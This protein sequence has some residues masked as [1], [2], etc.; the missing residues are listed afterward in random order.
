[1]V[2]GASPSPPG[3]RK[4]DLPGETPPPYTPVPALG[5]GD[6]APS[7]LPSKIEALKTAFGSYVIVR[8]IAVGGMG[9]V[10]EGWLIPS[11]ELAAQLLAGRKKELRVVVGV[12]SREDWLSREERERIRAWVGR[13]TEEFLRNPPSSD[14]YREMIEWISPH[15]RVGTDYRRAIKILNPELSKNPELVKRFV[16]EVEFL[17]R[18]NHPNIVKV[19]E[20][21]Q[22]GPFH[23]A[24]ME[25]VEAVPL[26]NLRLSIPEFVHVIRRALEGLI[27]AHEQNVL[28]RDLK[29][30]NLLVSED[31]AKIKL[32]DF[33]IAKA[34]DEAVDGHLTATGVIIGT[35]FYLDPERARGEP[36]TERSDVYSLG[37]TLYR[38]LTGEPPAKA[39]RPME[40]IALIQQDKD[41]PWVRTAN[42][43]VSSELEDAVMMMLSKNASKR[44][45][46]YEARILL[47]DLDGKNAL[48]DLE[49]TK[50]QR[51]AD[52][53]EIHKIK[54]EV[55]QVHKSARIAAGASRSALALKLYA[56]YEDLAELHPRDTVAGVNARIDA[57]EQALEFHRKRMK[58]PQEKLPQAVVDKIGMLEKRCALEYRRLV[59]HGFPRKVRPIR[60]MGRMALFAAASVIIVIMAV[61][62]SYNLA[63]NLR[64]RGRI[65][66]ALQEAENAL[67]S[68]DFAA[69]R[70]S[71]G[72]A[73]AEAVDLPQSAPRMKKLSALVDRAQTSEAY[74]RAVSRNEAVKR[75]ISERKYSQ[76]A[77]EIENI[78]KLLEETV[79]GADEALDPKIDTI[80]KGIAAEAKQIQAYDADIKVYGSLMEAFA[81]VRGEYQRLNVA[82]GKNEFFARKVAEDLQSKADGI[83]RKLSNPEVVNPD[84]VGPE[85]EKTLGQ[86][87]E[88]H[89]GITALPSQLDA[90][91]STAVR[92]E[93]DRFDSLLPTDTPSPKDLPGKLVGAYGALK[94]AQA[95]TGL[96]ARTSPQ[97][98][99]LRNRLGACRGRHQKL[100]NG[101]C[102][103]A[104]KE[105]PQALSQLVQAYQKAGYPVRAKEL[106]AKYPQAKSLPPKKK[107][108]G[109]KNPKK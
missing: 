9:E 52:A 28:H 106:L 100:E 65:D 83:L 69:T 109:D 22:S 50:A 1:M 60:R 101:F 10:W 3:D 26:E 75:F 81:E 71:L 45:T 55:R 39:S 6:I 57:Y 47:K 85:F 16:Q 102:E 82:L 43:R 32:S 42:A 108:N 21:G 23:Y 27:H 66:Q 29:P 25:Y 17:S 33:G 14:Q 51:K 70:A 93:L 49:P 86:V 107:P 94:R 8:R 31:I 20:S 73:R 18:L 15:R 11:V 105:T 41:P 95:V 67:A 68:G 53:R 89:N 2:K 92:K 37:A 87:K 80:R 36:S 13:R 99:E 96:M 24:A 40:T 5:E 30:S 4:S 79:S 7:V 62:F 103:R 59:Q 44:L 48:L 91:Q 34:L 76:A 88:V 98:E 78:R 63:E 54:A 74:V 35:P 56:R 61:L 58:A 97:R 84:A 104:A 46:S 72:R 12:H 38:L 77:E 64:V 19:V 90:A